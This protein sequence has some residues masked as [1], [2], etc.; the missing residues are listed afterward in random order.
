[1]ATA[2]LP[3]PGPTADLGSSPGGADL[4]LA[5]ALGEA[6]DSASAELSTPGGEAPGGEAGSEPSP[7]VEVPS[8][9]PGGESQASPPVEQPSA[10]E[11]EF[12]LAPDGQNYLVPKTALP[13]LQSAQQFRAQV[14][15]IFPDLQSA[16][17]ANEQAFSFRHLM[18]D[19]V[20][21]AGDPQ[22]VINALNHL[23]G[24]NETNPQ[25]RAAFQNSFA[26]MAFQLPQVLGQINPQA[27]QQL[28]SGLGNQYL[29]SLSTWDQLAPAVHDRMIE[30]LYQRAAQTQ[31]PNIFKAAQHLDYIKGKTYKTDLSQ[32]QLPKPQDPLATQRQAFEAQQKQ[33]AQAQTAA[34]QR[35]SQGFDSQ[36]LVGAR[37]RG[38]AD[39]ISKTTEPLKAHYSEKALSDMRDGVYRDILGKLQSQ[40]DWWLEHEQNYNIIMRQ[41]EQTWRSGSPGQGLAPVAN[42]FVQNFLSRAKTLLPAAVKARQATTPLKPGPKPRAAGQGPS[43]QTPS[44]APQTNGAAKSPGQDWNQEWNAEW[45]K[46]RRS[47]GA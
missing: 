23:A 3:S 14:G 26:Q 24:G 34:L 46:I 5:G 9:V 30:A 19:W 36:V 44:P 4:D 47:V 35:D 39:L 25:M 15:E 31:D 32:V 33:F 41:F 22:G 38:L 11:G 7:P 21:G 6:F 28:V 12:P 1:M 27:Y 20:L 45:D 16:Q 2:T 37:N 17:A 13:E 42:S 10:S 40:S 18:N 43:A 8:E 29:Q